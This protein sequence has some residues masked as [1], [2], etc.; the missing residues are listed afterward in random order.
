MSMRR[1]SRAFVVAEHDK[2]HQRVIHVDRQGEIARQFACDSLPLDIQ[3]LAGGNVL[4]NLGLAVVE[5]DHEFREIWRYSTS[6]MAFLSCQKLGNGNVLLGDTGEARIIEV[7]PAGKIVRSLPFRVSVD[8]VPHYNM[9]RLFRPLDEAGDRLLVACFHDRKLAE[10]TWDGRVRWQ[11]PVEGTPYMPI[12]LA[13]GNTLVS[14]GPTGRIVEVDPAG[15][16][17]WRYDMWDDNRLERGWISGISLLGDGGIVYSDS[18]H[19]RLVEISREREIL[20]IFQNRDI[21]L[22]PSTHVIVET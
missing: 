9:F 3:V 19:D 14:L 16:V 7:S 21:L 8:C 2:R 15:D 5:L 13:S 12:R 1:F 11:V 10:L 18:K 6:K 22:H 20:G 17:V 4:V